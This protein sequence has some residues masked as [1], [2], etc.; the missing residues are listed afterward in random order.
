MSLDTPPIYDG[1]EPIYKFKR[2]WDMYIEN[3]TNKDKYTNVLKFINNVFK[4]EYKNLLSIKE[5][6]EKNIPTPKKLVKLI[7]KE[8]KNCFDIKYNDTSIAIINN[9]LNIISYSL[10][11]LT[12]NNKTYYRVKY[13]LT[14]NDIKYE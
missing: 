10:I 7:N 5:L 12:K 8:F 9:I 6:D 13:N 14:Q 2:R 11:M 3:K 1:D 4:T